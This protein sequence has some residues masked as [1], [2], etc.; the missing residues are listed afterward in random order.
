MFN[1]LFGSAVDEIMR[2]NLGYIHLV[3]N[4][5]LLWPGSGWKNE[6]NPLRMLVQ[7]LYIQWLIRLISGWGNTRVNSY[8]NILSGSFGSAVEEQAS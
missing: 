3:A 6:I 5:W 4:V 2:N 8:N 1:D 7:D